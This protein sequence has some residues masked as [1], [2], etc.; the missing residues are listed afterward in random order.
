MPIRPRICIGKKV[1]LKPTNMIQNW[2]FPMRS[3][4]I[5]PEIF[6]HQKYRAAKIAKTLPPNST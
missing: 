3:L 6:G 2:I 5:Q 1:R 4:S